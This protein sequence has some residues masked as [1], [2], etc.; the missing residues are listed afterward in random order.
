MIRSGAPCRLTALAALELMVS[1]A[2]AVL[3]HAKDA[4][5]EAVKVSVSGPAA[6][7]AWAWKGI[8]TVAPGVV[9]TAAG[10]LSA[11]LAPLT[12]ACAGALRA[13][14]ERTLPPLAL[15]SSSVSPVA[16]PV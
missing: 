5:A 12:L 3:S 16:V 7:R 11:A 10:R 2:T 6:T 15:A 4:P 1:P 8:A 14:L 9:V 13:R